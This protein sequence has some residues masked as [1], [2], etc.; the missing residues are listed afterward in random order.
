MS[1]VKAFHSW[2]RKEHH[3]TTDNE[4]EGLRA[5]LYQATKTHRETVTNASKGLGID[6]HLFALRTQLEEME[7]PSPELFNHPALARS[8]TWELSTSHVIAPLAMSHEGGV[9]FHP[10]SPSSTGIVYGMYKDAIDIVVLN[11]A[12]GNR[13]DGQEFANRIVHS[14]QALVKLAGTKSS[15]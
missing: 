5:L 6:R 8:S 1:F 11:N 14:L 12:S 2:S 10:V 7:L 9:S 3:N 15:L 4:E 13:I